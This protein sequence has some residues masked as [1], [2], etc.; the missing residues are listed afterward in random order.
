MRR[1]V[2]TLL[3]FTVMLPAQAEQVL[4]TFGSEYFSWREYDGDSKLLEETG[5][6]HFVG[7]EAESMPGANW[8]Y[9]LRSRLYLGR[10][11]YDG[12]TQ[13]GV[14]HVT[15]TDYLGW[16]AEL[17][18]TR[19]FPGTLASA[20]VWGVKLALGYDNWRRDLADNY[21]PYIGT[22]VAGYTEDYRVGYGRLGAVYSGSQ[23]WS[24][25]GGVKLPFFTSER[26]GLTRLGYD[27]DPVLKPK[28]DYS[29]YASV[30][31]HLN[32]RWNLG[33]YYDSY[34]FR[35][36]DSALVTGGSLGSVYQPE[37]QQDTIGFY[38]NYRF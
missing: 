6:R 34:R 26:A 22:T 25:Q 38:L 9:A 7:L 3:L 17:D 14:P 29:L 10:V 15:D 5:L 19:H 8:I 24:L 16:T 28:P 32:P 36:S 33:G 2:A 30:S 35:R 20:P 23:G 18:F 31:Y 1:L 37:S 21:N 11:D 27:S 13:S 4:V 12:Q